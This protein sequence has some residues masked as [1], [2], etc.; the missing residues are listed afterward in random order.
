MSRRPSP[1]TPTHLAT[2]T[3]LATLVLV[4]ALVAASLPVPGAVAA[5]QEDG[6]L[7]YEGERLT[8]EAGPGQPILGQTD[9]PAGTTVTV[10]IRSTG[11]NPFLDT[12][13]AVVGSDGRFRAVLAF[14][15]VPVGTSFDVTVRGD[16]TSIATAEGEVV[17]C[18]ES[19]SEGMAAAES[20][21]DTDGDGTLTLEA[22]PGQAVEGTVERAAGTRVSVR[23]QS[24]GRSPF[25]V[26]TEAV[27]DRDGRFRTVHDLS[28]A[29]PGMSFE[30]IVH[31]DGTELASAD[32][33]VVECETDCAPPADDGGSATREATTPSGDEL[34]LQSVVSVDQGDVARITVGLGDAE[35]AMLSVG[36]PDVNFV[37]NVTVRDGDGDGLVEV[38]FST[39]SAGQPESTALAADEDD[40]A[41][42]PDGG[43]TR[44]SPNSW[45]L[46][47][48]DYPMALYTG[49]NTTGE[50]VD[51]G[52]LIIR[53]VPESERD[54]TP[55][56][57][58]GLQFRESI[59]PVDR[60]ELARFSVGLGDAEAAT[61]SIGGP[62]AGWWANV[63]VHDG[64]DEDRAVVLRLDTTAVA[65]GGQVFSAA[66]SGD[67]VTVEDG[68]WDGVDAMNG[69]IPAGDYE[70]AL[71]R[72]TSAGGERTDVGTLIVEREIVAGS[73]VES[74]EDPTPAGA[75]A[76][77][78]PGLVGGLGLIGIGGA[79]AV[80]GLALLLGVFRR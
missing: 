15:D 77:D 18:T 9:L 59:V 49:P 28:D 8:V 23:L 56:W 6:T 42:V 72:G 68:T 33:T 32:G 58:E 40:L 35:S 20:A 19:C 5:A 10:R 29:Q 63:T 39:A 46:D 7:L 75:D 3:R 66:H 1:M 65:H 44:L 80:V 14:D 67:S 34:A 78:D 27:V 57:S 50:Q 51:V 11:E 41:R 22:G 37:S 43:E 12:A 25:L 54:P 24:T 16:G 52:T 4:T 30:A 36:G 2:P 17:E 70:F 69:S 48:G 26:T 60:T 13:E 74:V 55:W 73:V 71:Y 62:E 31:H 47:A 21:F 53:E 61:V 76:A 79:L 45:S 38:L 64:H